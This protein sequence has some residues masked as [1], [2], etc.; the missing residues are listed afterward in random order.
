MPGS[1]IRHFLFQRLDG[2]YKIRCPVSPLFK[3]SVFWFLLLHHVPVAIVSVWAGKR[4][5]LPR[6][7]KCLFAPCK[8]FASWSKKNLHLPLLSKKSI[9]LQK[10]LTAVGYHGWQ[11]KHLFF[12]FLFSFR[13][14][15]KF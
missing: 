6:C 2:F 13:F 9:F 8:G 11:K 3:C 15:E 7:L 12:L 1:T 10:T 5:S 14:G 4:C